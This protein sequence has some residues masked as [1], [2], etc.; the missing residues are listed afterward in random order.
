MR[1]PTIIAAAGTER[2]PSPVT[3]VL[4]VAAIGYVLWPRVQGQPLATKLLAV[5]PALLIGRRPAGA[6]D[7]HSGRRSADRPVRRQTKPDP[8]TLAEH[9]VARFQGPRPPGS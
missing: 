4:V 6:G 2:S 9:A 7:P 3:I 1:M 8:I 5:L